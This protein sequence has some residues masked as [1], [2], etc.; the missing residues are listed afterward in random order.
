MSELT[1][2]SIEKSDIKPVKIEP[3]GTAIV[4]QR[5]EKYER[6]R[7][8]DKSGSVF[9]EDAAEARKRA[10]D[11]FTQELAGDTDESPI[12]V[13]FASSDTQYNDMG[14]RSL[15]TAQ[16]AQDAC[17]EAMVAA[18]V[19]PNQRIINFSSDF[20]TK[21]FKETDQDIRPVTKLREPD[22]FSSA[23]YINHLRDKYGKEDGPGTGISKKAWAAHEADEEKEAREKFGAEGVGEILGRTQK[24]IHVFEQYAAMFHRSRPNARLVIWATSHYDTISP[25]VKDAT[26]ATLKDYVPVDYG[27]GI[28]IEV[29]PGSNEAVFEAQGQKTL[30]KLGKIATR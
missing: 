19:E 15:E 13:L 24:S 20:T 28:V 23:D 7:D 14:R 27:A 16:L 8:S 22:I 21:R 4:L 5:H 25:L 26:G 9:E 2:P 29:G 30:L 6:S 3:G 10:L 18:G 17:A 12:F 11:F 1:I